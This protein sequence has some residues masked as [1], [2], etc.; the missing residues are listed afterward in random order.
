MI[1]KESFGINDFRDEIEVGLSS[2]RAKAAGIVG[3][4]K[5]V[6]SL[7]ETKKMLDA[8][9]LEMPGGKWIELGRMAKLRVE[10]RTGKTPTEINSCIVQFERMAVMHA[11]LRARDKKGAHMPK[12]QAECQTLIQIDMASGKQTGESKE[13]QKKLKKAALKTSNRR[14]GKR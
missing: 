8:M 5:E 13:V 3:S 7:K 9:A 11:W 10:A 6:E 14:M 1:Q 2:W 4:N 12:T